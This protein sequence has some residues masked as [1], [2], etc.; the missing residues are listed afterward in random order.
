[1]LVID[2][3]RR[4]TSLNVRKVEMYARFHIKKC[5]MKCYIEECVGLICLFER[6][7]VREA[8]CVGGKFDGKLSRERK[9]IRSEF[10]DS[11]DF[12][13]DADA[14]S[15]C[16]KKKERGNFLKQEKSNEYEKMY[17]IFV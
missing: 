3:R 6:H 8:I 10:P 12:S 11:F 13:S 14:L 4:P 15:R 5:V 16:G 9:Y 2:F 17:E 7:R 1:M